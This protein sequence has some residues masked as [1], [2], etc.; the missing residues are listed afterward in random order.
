MDTHRARNQDNPA[1]QPP[2]FAGSLP[3]AH[4][5]PEKLSPV[6]FTEIFKCSKFF[7]RCLALE[8]PLEMIPVLDLI[9]PVSDYAGNYE[10]PR[11]DGYIRK[12]L[13]PRELLGPAA[14][15]VI[16]IPRFVEKFIQG[17]Y[18][19]GIIMKPDSSAGGNGV[20]RMRRDTDR[21]SMKLRNPALGGLPS[22][23]EMLA[24]AR[25]NTDQIQICGETEPTLE[26]LID[27]SRPSQARMFLEEL[28]RLALTT[29]FP[30][31]DSRLF[32]YADVNSGLVEIDT[33][34][35]SINS[36]MVEGRY[37][38]MLRDG[39]FSIVRSQR[40]DG[41]PLSSCL[42]CGNDGEFVNGGSVIGTWPGM[43]QPLIEA[44]SLEC[45]VEN[46]D[47]YM[48]ELLRKVTEHMLISMSKLCES[49]PDFL[50]RIE[51]ACFQIDIAWSRNEITAVPAQNNRPAMQ[52]PHPFLME[53]LW[54]F[55]V[56]GQSA[57][58]D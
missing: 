44:A 14:D 27:L 23:A 56:T 18:P 7:Q 55:R 25:S 50:A 53:V 24:F 19:A 34:L 38:T 46:F 8:G 15:S 36:R 57:S 48:Y 51:L 22:S 16:D 29:V 30:H 5:K 17:E 32:G 10:P 20:T 39:E 54:N 11:P 21:I 45:S 3:T 41:S 37:Y 2:S 52:V 40:A 35:L 49:P 31:K 58:T 26:L 28:A 43:H 1:I 13:I 47:S 42:K 4:W 12:R 6:V 9:N 33:A